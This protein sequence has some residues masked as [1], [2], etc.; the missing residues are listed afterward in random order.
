MSTVIFFNYLNVLTQKKLK[1]RFRYTL[2]VRQLYQHAQSRQQ[3]CN[4]ARNSTKIIP[5]LCR[6]KRS[7]TGFFFGFFALLILILKAKT[8]KM[9]KKQIFYAFFV[10]CILCNDAAVSLCP[11]SPI[12]HLLCMFVWKKCNLMFHIHG[13]YTDEYLQPRQQSIALLFKIFTSSRA[14][15]INKRKSF[16][17]AS[18]LSN[19]WK[20]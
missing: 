4:S 2:Q 14:K 5:H 17:V 3:N 6:A 10:I 7:H 12:V 8:Y 16:F 9:E 1:Q 11:P 13:V 18:L 20:P 19:F 15:W